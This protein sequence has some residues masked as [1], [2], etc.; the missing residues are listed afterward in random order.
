MS[1]PGTGGS[2]WQPRTVSGPPSRQCG[3]GGSRRHGMPVGSRAQPPAWAPV[4]DPGHVRPPGRGAHHH[5]HAGVPAGLC[6]VKAACPA[7]SGSV[8]GEMLGRGPRVPTQV[9][10]GSLWATLWTQAAC[11]PSQQVLVGITVPTPCHRTQYLA[12]FP[13]LEHSAQPCGS[14]GCGQTVWL[15]EGCSGSVQR[16]GMPRASARGHGEEGAL[17]PCASYGEA[18]YWTQGSPGACPSSPRPWVS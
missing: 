12:A 17:A 13:S 5:L 18:G 10:Y 7:A 11:G 3:G 15:L 14:A 4:G 9:P 16:R 6:P 8:L 2:V 1:V